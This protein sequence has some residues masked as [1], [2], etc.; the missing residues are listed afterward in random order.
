MTQSASKGLCPVTVENLPLYYVRAFSAYPNLV[1]GISTRQ[2][3]ISRAPYDSLNL[4]ASVGDKPEVVANNFR[5]FCQALSITPEETVSCH[6]V[7]SA[8]VLTIDR[9]N[10]QRVMGQADGLI[11]GEPGIYL[12]MRFGDCTPLI[13]FDPVRGAVGLTHAGWR[14]TLQNAA[15]ATVTALERQLGCR[16]QD[17]IAVIGPAIGP[18][19]YE[20]GPDVIEAAGNIFS[21]P[22][23]LF[24]RRNCDGW[25]AHFNMWEANRRQLAAAGVKEIILSEVC[26]A[27]QTDEFFSHRAEHGRTGR[28]GVIIGL[29]GAVA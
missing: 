8:R 4:G 10:R 1:H 26:T 15:G 5:L 7:H 16:P 20:V 27:C 19:C 14:G 17:I 18:C 2:G 9:A 21:D 13:F 11:T 23:S 29:R 22:G 6:L 12:A 24:E 28:F 25:H 3:G